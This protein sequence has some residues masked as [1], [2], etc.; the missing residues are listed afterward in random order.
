MCNLNSY[1]KFPIVIL[2]FFSYT[3]SGQVITAPDTI[4]KNLKEPINLTYYSYGNTYPWGYSTGHNY[5]GSEEWAEKYYIKGNAKVKGVISHHFG[6]VKGLTYPA[7]FNVYNVGDNRKPSTKITHKIIR[8]GDIDLSGKA[9]VTY[10]NTV[11]T[12]VDSFFVSFNLFDYYHRPFTDTIGLYYGVD[13]SRP[14]ADLINFGRNC[15]RKH[16]HGPPVWKDFYSQNNT[17]VATHF[18]IYP[19]IEFSGTTNIN[20]YVGYSGIKMHPVFPNPAKTSVSI[21]YDLD[22]VSSISYNITSLTGQ[23]VK[24]EIV[25]MQNSGNN[26]IKINNLNIASGTYIFTLQS[27]KGALAQLLIVE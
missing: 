23:L 12:V 18:A 4:L 1:K 5:S 13:G 7:E 26:E 8:Y 19:I 15:I 20:Q 27:N 11:A 6:T 22:F 9:M 17:P 14:A 24:S 2:L 21:L 3:V 16:F 10:F 25:G